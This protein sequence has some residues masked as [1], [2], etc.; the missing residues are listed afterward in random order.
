MRETKT[1]GLSPEENLHYKISKITTEKFIQKNLT[2][3]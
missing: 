2:N 1:K 3:R